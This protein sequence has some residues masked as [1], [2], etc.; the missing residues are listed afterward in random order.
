MRPWLL[1]LPLVT[2]GCLYL[3]S[4]D[5]PPAV[6]LPSDS[7]TTANKGGRLT[8]A[9]V[10]SDPDDDAA[11]LTVSVT[12]ADAQS[13][14]P[15]DPQCD[16]SI[17]PVG[18]AFA[19]TFYRVGIFQVT[20]TVSDP[21]HASNEASEMVTVTDALPAF[22]AGATIKQTSLRDLCGLNTAGDVLTLELAAPLANEPAVADADADA[23]KPGCTPRD[24]LAYTW[25]VSDAPGAAMPVLTR[26]D[27]SSCAPPTADSGPTLA[28]ADPKEQVCL[29]T[30]PASAD[31]TTMYSVVLD[32]TDDA[33]DPGHT[34]T[35]PAGNIPVGADQPPC[36]S[37]TEPIAGSWVV[38]RTELQEF[39]VDHVDDD[40]DPLVPMSLL[41]F[42]WSVW[43]EDDPVWRD[44][45]D[46]TLSN[47]QLDV[48]SFGVGEKVR[49][50][51]EAVDRTGARVPASSC[52]VDADDCVVAS[53]ASAPNVCHKWKTWDL[54]LR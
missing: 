32:V 31:A 52:P 42:A 18:R 48:S 10:Y 20:V 4:I 34:V 21:D 37:G 26:Y 46:W 54:E 19:V 5:Q 35:S 50:R 40:R 28:V 17:D 41:T 15:L 29:W 22:T 38:D 24:V 25:R 6:S 7:L 11:K 3:D 1:L 2:S 36:I 27:G 49:V 45:P 9:P 16:Y 51:V 30:D 13:A 23:V 8:V 44:V 47:Y 14:A 43:R 12:V 33:S 39:I 53:C